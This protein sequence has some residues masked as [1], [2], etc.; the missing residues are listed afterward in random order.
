ME[1]CIAYPCSHCIWPVL[2]HPPRILAAA[3]ATMTMVRSLM[4]A[5]EKM[6]WEARDPSLLTA[7][8]REQKRS[9]MLLLLF[10]V[11]ESAW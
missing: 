7:Q 4:L 2:R 11:Q 3:H 1:E 6:T 8:Q 10:H 5:F 9:L